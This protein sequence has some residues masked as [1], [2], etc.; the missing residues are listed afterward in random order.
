MAIIKSA[1]QIVSPLGYTS[2]YIIEKSYKGNYRGFLSAKLHMM[3]EIRKIAAKEVFPFA[4]IILRTKEKQQVSI[5]KIER[6]GRN[7][8]VK[9]FEQVV[10]DI[11]K[12]YQ[13]EI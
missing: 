2:P 11:P 4:N 12:E 5:M 3:Q 6:D 8:Y 1:I 10:I 7:I 9:T 13:K